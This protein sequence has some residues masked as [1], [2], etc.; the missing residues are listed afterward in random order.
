MKKKEAL[1]F[2]V[3]DHIIRLCLTW[4]TTHRSVPVGGCSRPS[5]LRAWSWFGWALE[6]IVVGDKISVSLRLEDPRCHGNNNKNT[7][8]DK[9]KCNLLL[10][11]HGTWTE[12]SC[13]CLSTHPSNIQTLPS[14]LCSLWQ[15]WTK[16]WLLSHFRSCHSTCP[17]LLEW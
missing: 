4:D 13:V 14:C 1:A 2:S 9:R 3:N 16:S 7:T 6:K 8:M 10:V 15:V 17:T 5:W 11:A 12:V